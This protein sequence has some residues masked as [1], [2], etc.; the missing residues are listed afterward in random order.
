[1]LKQASAVL[2][3]ADATHSGS[4]VSV[5]PL[6]LTPFEYYYLLEDRCDYPAVFQIQLECRGRI[7]RDAFSKA[8]QLAH[9]R[10][11]LLSARL[12]KAA[13]GWP[14]WV[15]GDAQPIRWNDDSPPCARIVTERQWR[16]ACKSV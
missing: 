8:Y 7:N 4:A 12:E 6:P 13:N 3:N 2:K 16:L 9:A 15:T 5:F 10:H 1:M 11:P 14:Q